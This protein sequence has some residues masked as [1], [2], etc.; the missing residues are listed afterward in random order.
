[1]ISAITGIL[2][3]RTIVESEFFTSVLYPFAVND[4]MTVSNPVPN[5]GFLIS[6]GEIEFTAISNPTLQSGALTETI[7]FK[8]Y[9]E[10]LATEQTAISNPTLQSG[11][12][13]ETIVFKTYN[14]PLATEQTAISN[15]TLQSGTLVVTINYVDYNEPLATEQT[16]ISNP[17]LLSGTLI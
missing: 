15:P 12:L 17:T 7:V 5:T 2:A 4:V 10:P 13:T 1:M 8:T 14:E 3:S 6:I 16:L 9:N 11:A